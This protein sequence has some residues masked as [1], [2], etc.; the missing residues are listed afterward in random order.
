MKHRACNRPS[1][2]STLRRMSHAMLIPTRW[3]GAFSALV[4]LTACSSG[5]P[6]PKSSDAVDSTQSIAKTESTTAPA[7]TTAST[8]APKNTEAATGTPTKNGADPN[9]IVGGKP[10]QLTRFEIERPPFAYVLKNAVKVDAGPAPI[11]KKV[12]E[13]KNNITD[14]LEWFEKN[15]LQIAGRKPMKSPTTPVAQFPGLETIGSD[16]LHYAL[17]HADHIILMYG[18]NFAATTTLLLLDKDKIVRGQFD[19]SSFVKPNEVEAGKE[20]ITNTEVFW[21]EKVGD[22]LY[23]S[24]GH[25]TYS[26]TTKGKNAF[27]TAIDTNTGSVRWQSDPLVCNASNFVVY[28]SYIICSYGFTDEPDFI[29]VISRADGKTVSKIPIKSGAQYLIMKGNQL[30]VR[31]YDT[32]YVFDVK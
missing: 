12:S 29:Y 30:F 4:M 16:K 19:F 15:G 13:K 7:T 10:Y 9:E 23:A 21:A 6:T 11:L 17:E 22:I 1:Y 24:T 31:A 2:W 8:A 20:Y 27:L 25:H 28:G 32:D 5:Q 14:D 18:A 26:K 3:F